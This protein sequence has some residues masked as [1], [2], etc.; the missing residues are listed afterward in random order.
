VIAYNVKKIKIVELEGLLCLDAIL[1][2]AKTNRLLLK[3][4]SKINTTL[5][6]WVSV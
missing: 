4:Y 6:V 5:K 1:V 3:V 2:A